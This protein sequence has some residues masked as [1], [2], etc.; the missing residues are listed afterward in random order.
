MQAAR[1]DYSV[2]FRALSELPATHFALRGGAEIWNDAVASLASQF[3]DLT[4]LR[5]WLEK[6]A[7]LLSKCHSD[8]HQPARDAIVCQQCKG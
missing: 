8:W 3:S 5:G 7:A 6:Y 1:A 4:P 2:T